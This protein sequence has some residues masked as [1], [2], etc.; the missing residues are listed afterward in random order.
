MHEKRYRIENRMKEDEKKNTPNERI[1]SKVKNHDEN[2][3]F[4]LSIWNL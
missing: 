2:E 1:L 3:E 4:Y